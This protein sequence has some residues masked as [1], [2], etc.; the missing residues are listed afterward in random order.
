MNDEDL[1]FAE[2]TSVYELK[3]PIRY[4]CSFSAVTHP[5][6]RGTEVLMFLRYLKKKNQTP[7]Q[8]TKRERIQ[9]LRR[10]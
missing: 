2:F 1:T 7:K 3:S 4:N 9:S 8:Y 10:L 5:T 6:H